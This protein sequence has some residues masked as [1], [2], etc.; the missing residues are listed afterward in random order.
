MLVESANLLMI[1]SRLRDKGDWVRL[2]QSFMDASRAALDA[3]R[4]RRADAL[5]ASGEAIDRSCD[6]CHEKYQK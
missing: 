3:A 1:G 4:A 2:S 6:R 5:F